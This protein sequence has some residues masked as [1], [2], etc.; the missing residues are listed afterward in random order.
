MAGLLK[1][2]LPDFFE[3]FCLGKKIECEEK[4]HSKKQRVTYKLPSWTPVRGVS[5]VF[6]QRLSR[7]LRRSPSR[8][9]ELPLP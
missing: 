6:Y 4:S 3:F 1:L 2:L 5:T 7:L 9:R 8:L